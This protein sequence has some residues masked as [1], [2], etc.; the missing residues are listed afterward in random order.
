M[1]SR[2]LLVVAGYLLGSIPFG[3]VLARA[4]GVDPRKV[5]SGNIG[6]S[7][8]ARSAGKA[9]GIATLLLDVAKASLPMLAARALLAGDP[10]AEGWVMA[11]GV[12]AFVGH[13]F[14]VWLG[15]HGGKGV[16][17]GLG[18]FAVAAP[19]AA[20]VAVAAFGIAFAATRIAAVGSLAGTTVCVA[21]A[22]VQ[23]GGGS[24]VP[25]IGLVVGAAI[26]WRHRSNVARLVRG[27][28]NKV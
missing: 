12:A 21:G 17:T 11:V 5:G 8:V 15:F 19:W 24:P 10:A 7:N 2:I 4:K 27:A 16:A 23:R 18:V 28:E 1:I 3:V 9:L 6:A 20:L 22:F 26:F 14:P 13:V 25:W